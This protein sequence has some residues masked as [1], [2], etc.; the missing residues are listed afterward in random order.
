MDDEKIIALY[1]QRDESAITATDTKYGAL[2][3]TLSSGIVAS[4]E[5]AEECVNDTYL[6][7][8]N[9]IP[10][11]RP[12]RF[13]AYICAVVRNISV[14]RV[15]QS[16][17][18]R[19]GGGEYTAALDELDECIPSDADPARRAEL[20]ELAVAVDT[21][22]SALSPDERKIFMCRYWLVASTA[23]TAEI[24]GCSE[25]KVKTSLHR[26]RKKLKKHLEEEGLV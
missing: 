2:L 16:C 25:A 15:R 3:R 19:R 20:R 11:Q 12:H 14:S 8:W 24:V 22:L 18:K 26:T 13:G 17:L 5:D 6:A 23:R 4:R 9:A 10:P 7:A 1:W 21:F